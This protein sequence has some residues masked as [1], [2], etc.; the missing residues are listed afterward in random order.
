MEFD[1]PVEKLGNIKTGS[2]QVSLNEKV[3]R[4]LTAK[5]FCYITEWGHLKDKKNQRLWINENGLRD[6]WPE[7]TADISQP[8][9]CFLREIP[10]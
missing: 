1:F 9:H 5:A 8:H 6:M 7:K 2:A 3:F 10:Y 4:R